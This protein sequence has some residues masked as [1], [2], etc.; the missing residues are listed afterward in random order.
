M[1]L[2]TKWFTSRLLP[3]VATILMFAF[4]HANAWATQ[5]KVLY[6]FQGGSDGNHPSGALTLDSAGNLYGTT[7]FG[8]VTNCSGYGA[9]GCG[10]VF[11][12]ARGSGGQWTESVLHAFQVN[13]D[14]RDG[15]APNGALIFDAAG[16]LY[17]TTSVGGGG[18]LQC[19]SGAY[20]G[21]GIVFELTP[22]SGGNWTETVL[23]RF[24]V[25]AGGAGP[26]AGLV[27]D[28]AGN[29]YGTTAAGGNCCGADIFGWGAGGVFELTTTSGVWSEE[30]LHYFCS[31]ANCTDGNAPYSGL[32]R[33]SDGTLY[34]TTT[35]GGSSSFPCYNL[36]CGT[37][38]E[39]D[40]KKEELA[41]PLT[42][43]DGVQT[44]SSLTSDANGNFYGTTPLDGASGDG[45][46]FRLSP[47]P[48]GRWTFTVLYNFH[49]GFAGE[50][51]F[52]TGVVF[53]K[54]GNLYGTV[55][56]PQG[57]NCEGWGCGLVY[58]L[59]PQPKGPWKYSVVYTFTGAEDGGE[60]NG[61]LIIDDQGN[62]YGTTA[63]GG[64]EYGVVY[65]I[66]P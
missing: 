39:L 16:N 22:A 8:G 63:I 4:F 42:G 47:T 40:S 1:P 52:A 32:L 58:K 15:A 41:Y 20:V 48:E 46:V 54:A 51:S 9:D 2:Q 62:L 28:E 14:D 56:G 59:E 25:N 35:Y 11:M 44:T 49:G 23:H 57:G 38:F 5:Y 12:L 30:V 66:T 7:L 21:C 36:G 60:P 29:L 31:K 6:T 24:N 19:S 26:Y 64:A 37:V 17:G 43:I 55:W 45:T 61:T 13:N 27:M 18:G 3:S 53:D 50:G 34:G 33:G 65:E 10:T